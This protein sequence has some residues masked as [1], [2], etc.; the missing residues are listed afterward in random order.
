[1]RELQTPYMIEFIEQYGRNWREEVLRMNSDRMPK[2]D[3]RI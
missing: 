1:M 3:P 2:D